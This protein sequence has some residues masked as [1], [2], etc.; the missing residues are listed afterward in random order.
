MTKNTE[1][2]PS[3][4]YLLTLIFLICITLYFIDGT[5]KKG[6]DTTI[7]TESETYDN[8]LLKQEIKEIAS[9]KKPIT[10]RDIYKKEKFSQH[11]TT[12]QGQPMILG[13][14]T[15][16]EGKYANFSD[17][18]SSLLGKIDV[19]KK[20]EFYND[21]PAP[22]S[23]PE[24]EVRVP[25]TVSDPG[26]LPDWY[27]SL[28]KPLIKRTK[29]QKI[30]TDEQ[31]IAKQNE[32]WELSQKKQNPTPTPKIYGNRMLI[33]VTPTPPSISKEVKDYAQAELDGIIN[34]AL[35]FPETPTLPPFVIAPTIG[36]AMDVVDMTLNEYE[37]IMRSQTPTLTPQLDFGYYMATPPP[38]NTFNLPGMG[39]TVTVTPEVQIDSEIIKNEIDDLMMSSTPQPEE[40]SIFKPFM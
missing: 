1:N 24:T 36:A 2:S 10:N 15:E 40:S 22:P 16:I 35:S 5:F 32:I 25:Q 33:D 39:Q 37:T 19:P 28:E 4:A 38:F 18:S 12:T 14:E 13:R 11:G 8:A 31:Q 30:L 27:D 7:F 21:L 26:S 23:L 17:I 20:I 9:E 3:D 6:V 34:T 29:E